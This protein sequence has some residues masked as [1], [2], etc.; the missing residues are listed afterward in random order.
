MNKCEDYTLPSGKEYGTC[1]NWSYLDDG[2]YIVAFFAKGDPFGTFADSTFTWVVESRAGE[3]IH[4][5]NENPQHMP[6]FGLDIRE[7][8]AFQD[9]VLVIVDALAAEKQSGE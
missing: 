5:S 6:V 4:L 3:T 1:M 7:W 2:D 8:R 9:R